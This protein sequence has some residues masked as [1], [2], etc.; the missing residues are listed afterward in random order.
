MDRMQALRERIS[1]EIQTVAGVRAEVELVEPRRIERFAGKA[2]RV[3][4]KRGLTE[5]DIG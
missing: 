3:L 4:D 5:V 2:K 1:R